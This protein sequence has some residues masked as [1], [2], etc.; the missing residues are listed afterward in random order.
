M[1]KEEHAEK[2]RKH[3][4]LIGK[5][6]GEGDGEVRCL[7]LLYQSCWGTGRK[8]DGTVCVH[9]ISCPCPRCTPRC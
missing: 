8:K 6:T 2:V 3:R 1:R 4:E 7:H 5:I 9:C